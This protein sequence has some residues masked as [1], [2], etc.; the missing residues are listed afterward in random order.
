MPKVHKRVYNPEKCVVINILSNYNC[1][2]KAENARIEMYP[3]EETHYVNHLSPIH[4]RV[5]P[6]KF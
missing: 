4:I 3:I 1:G 6:T 2:L 5:Y